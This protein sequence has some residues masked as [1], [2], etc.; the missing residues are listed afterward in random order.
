MGQKRPQKRTP[1]RTAQFIL[2]L[3]AGFVHPSGTNGDYYSMDGK[4]GQKTGIASPD[5][6]AD[7]RF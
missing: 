6:S 3:C 5:A 4:K 2:L 1:F 7:G